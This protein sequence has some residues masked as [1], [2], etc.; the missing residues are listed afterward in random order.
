MNARNRFFAF[1][2]LLLIIVAAYYFFSTD[3]S[4]DLVLI[5][6]VD[7]NQVV[8]SPKISG[9]I[10]RLA[11]D[12]GT[13]VKAGDTIAVL[14]SQELTA[15]RQAAEAMLVS[16]RYQ[17]SQTR[18][19]EEQTAGETSSGV[20]NAQARLRAAQAT[21]LQA[22]ADLQRIQGDT[23]RAVTLAQQ[24]IASQQQ[25]DQAAAQLQAQEAL[26]RAAEDQSRAAQADLVTAQAH[27][28]QTQ[29][30]QSTVASTRAQQLNAKA[31]LEAAETRLGYTKVTAP[32]NGIVTVR[33]AREGEV[34]N[35]GQAIVIITDLSD[36]WVRAAIPETQA[37]HIALGDQLNARL[38]SGEIVSGKIIFKAPEADFATQRDVNRR[39]RDIKAITLKLA[40]ANGKKTLVPGM[41]AE[42][43]VPIA[44]VEGH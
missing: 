7:A 44:K 13:E 18:A 21:L 36:T 3:H 5:G 10:E 40:V 32:V 20:V 26:V 39:K 31:Q 25:A 8:V 17:V 1:L 43:L 15:D 6:T 42:I 24:G 11:V 9:R 33:A 19:T 16:L 41:T 23:R 30:A 34:V 28:R 4:S 27:T 2:G 29:A 38:P 14:D 35:L 12:E 22:Q 37:D